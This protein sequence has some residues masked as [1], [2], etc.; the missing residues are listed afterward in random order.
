MLKF[1][2]RLHEMDFPAEQDN[3]KAKKNLQSSRL[4]R[5]HTYWYNTGTVRYAIQTKMFLIS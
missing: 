5:E 3:L 2:C 4:Q 1:I